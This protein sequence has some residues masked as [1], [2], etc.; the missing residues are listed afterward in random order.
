[1]SWKPQVSIKG[2]WYDSDLAF[3]T[4]LDALFWGVDQLKR[5][6]L[7]EDFRAV[8]SDEPATHTIGRTERTRHLIEVDV[9]VAGILSPDTGARRQRYTVDMRTQVPA[10]S[11]EQATRL[12]PSLLNEHR[13]VI[14]IFDADW[15]DV[16]NL[17]H[18]LERASLMAEDPCTRLTGERRKICTVEMRLEVD[19]ESPQRAAALARK[20]IAHRARI[21]AVSDR[22]GREVAFN[23]TA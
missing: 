8:H 16:T 1:V 9:E 21:T 15:N 22:D 18:P 3:A 19:A 14:A 7:I 6:E 12:A 17:A 11:P 5:S 2:K 13:E 10:E 23:K 4:E 20:S